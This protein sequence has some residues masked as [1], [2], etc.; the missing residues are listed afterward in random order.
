MEG[1]KIKGEKNV[2]RE[3]KG[4]GEDGKKGS[5]KKGSKRKERATKRDGEKRS[6]AVRERKEEI[7]E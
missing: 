4:G 7:G 1:E 2:E 5:V 6:R 3:R